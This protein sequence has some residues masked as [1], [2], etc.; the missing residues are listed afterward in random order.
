MEKSESKGEKLCMSENWSS[1]CCIR[2]KMEFVV[3]YFSAEM[4]CLM[5]LLGHQGRT[6]RSTDVL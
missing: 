4:Y 6:D 5:G 1:A 2:I 3:V